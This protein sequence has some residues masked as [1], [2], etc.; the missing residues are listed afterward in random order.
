MFLLWGSHAQKKGARIDRRRH[1]VL[2]A[3][4]PSPL[5]AHRGF[6]GC[7]HFS[8]ANAWLASRGEAPIDW[9]LPPKGTLESVHGAPTSD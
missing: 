5:S 9:A 1:K 3:P 8:A 7:G 2:A 4:H 6:I